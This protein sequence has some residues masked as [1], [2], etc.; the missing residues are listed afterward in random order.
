MQFR[1][2][3]IFACLGGYALT[4]NAP[5]GAQTLNPPAPIQTQVP[6]GSAAVAWRAK[7]LLEEAQMEWKETQ[8]LTDDALQRELEPW[9]IAQMLDN[10]PIAPP[11]STHLVRVTLTEVAEGEPHR[12]SMSGDYIEDFV[13]PESLALAPAIAEYD[14]VYE[15]ELDES[16]SWPALMV[17]A[18]DLE[19]FD[20]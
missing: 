19:L 18:V 20:I 7:R 2:A 6:L 14:V 13:D 8:H 11:E 5:A 15:V 1:T 17:D 12:M 9:E 4:G 10:A 3:G 16:S